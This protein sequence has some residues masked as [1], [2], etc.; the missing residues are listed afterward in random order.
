MKQFIG[1]WQILLNFNM[2]FLVCLGMLQQHINKCY[3][4]LKTIKKFS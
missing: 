2:V 1:I 3:K 4:N